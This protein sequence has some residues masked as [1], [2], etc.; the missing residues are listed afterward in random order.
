[1]FSPPSPV[2]VEKLYPLLCNQPGEVVSPE[3]TSPRL[4]YKKNIVVVRGRGGRGNEKKKTTVFIFKISFSK[5][6]E[7][8]FSTPFI[9]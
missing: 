9:P 6:L 7:T 3:I 4:I 5:T 2:V 8:V 1:M